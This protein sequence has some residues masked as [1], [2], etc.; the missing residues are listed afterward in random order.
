[1]SENT[2]I[3]PEMVT[4]RNWTTG[5]KENMNSRHQ[6]TKLLVITNSQRQRKRTETVVRQQTTDYRQYEIREDIN[7][8]LEMATKRNY[9]TGYGGQKNS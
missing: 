5:N 2:N 9:D 4:K 1:M 6:N 7:I 8:K 3:A